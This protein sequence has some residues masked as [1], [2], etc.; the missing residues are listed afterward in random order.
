MLMHN[1]HWLD[2]VGFA[3]LFDPAHIQQC[4]TTKT[5]EKE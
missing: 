5:Q 1:L 4:N 2:Y 3:R